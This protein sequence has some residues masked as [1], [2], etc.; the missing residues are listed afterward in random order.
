MEVLLSISTPKTK[1]VYHKQGCIYEKKIKYANRMSVSKEIAEQN[2]YH[3]CKYCA[4][5]RGEIRVKS[6]ENAKW[7]RKENL[8]ITYEA[9]TDTVYVTTEAGAWKIFMNRYGKYVLF[10][11]NK[12]SSDMSFYEI[13]SADYHCQSDVKATSSFEKMI[14]YIVEHDKAKIIIMDDYRKLPQKTK[15]Q[16]KYYRQA[17]RKNRTRQK[18]KMDAIF[19][20][21]ESRNPEL[22]QYSMC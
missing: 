5:L 16:K 2:G 7:N 21:L 11:M 6:F 3:E 9:R 22:K 14:R 17:K 18:L 15:R 8:E 19:A 13:K 1:R 4:G 12:F 20:S 10:H